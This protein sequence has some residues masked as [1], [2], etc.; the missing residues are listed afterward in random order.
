MSTL[1]KTSYTVALSDPLTGLQVQVAFSSVASGQPTTITV[2]S[3]YG[4]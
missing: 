3:K 1:K 2:T 4:K